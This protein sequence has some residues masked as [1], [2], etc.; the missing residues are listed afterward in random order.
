MFCIQTDSIA[1]THRIHSLVRHPYTCRLLTYSQLANKKKYSAYL[2]DVVLSTNISCFASILFSFPPMYYYD[3]DK[4]LNLNRL[5]LTVTLWIPLHPLHLG[6]VREHERVWVRRIRR[7]RMSV[8]RMS[9]AKQLTRIQIETVERNASNASLKEWE[10]QS[11]K[12]QRRLARRHVALCLYMI[13][14]YVETL[15][16]MFV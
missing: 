1:R 12:S 16:M 4:M 13:I 7:V 2:C 8:C 6:D 5:V 9:A 14:L 11:K 10:K 15:L 3:S